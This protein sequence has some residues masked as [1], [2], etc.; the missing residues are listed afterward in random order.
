M[1][2]EFYA[3]LTFMPGGVFGPQKLEHRKTKSSEKNV[4]SGVKQSQVQIPGLPGINR[5]AVGK[6]LAYSEILFP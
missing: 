4:A 6:L 3:C 5:V 1:L 2:E